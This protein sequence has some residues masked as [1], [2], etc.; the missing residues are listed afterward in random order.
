MRKEE[1]NIYK[2]AELANVSAATVSKVINNRPGVSEDVRRKVLN[3][4]EANNFTPRT[5]VNAQNNIAVIFRSN[6]SI[7][8]LFYSEYMIC[9]MRGLCEYVFDHNYLITVFPSIMVPKTKS[10]FSIFCKKHKIVGCV[11]GNLRLED[12]YIEEISGV[13][14]LVLMNAVFKGDM[15]YSVCSDDY[16]GMYSAVRYLYEMGHRRIAIGAVGAMYY[17]NHQK[18]MGFKQ[19]VKDFGLG[20]DYEN[21]FD[22]DSFDPIDFCEKYKSLKEADRLPTA[23]ACMNDEETFRA[24]N[25]LRIINVDC[26]K[27]ISFV[28]YDDYE[29]S[30]MVF[31][32][33]T[34]VKQELYAMGKV[35]GKLACGCSPA[36]VGMP[37][38]ENQF[39][40]KTRLME[41]DTVARLI[42]E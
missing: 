23:I 6:D 15:V 19:A 3:C 32:A 10:E 17:A 22:F 1:M 36:A 16:N 34:T 13:V 20:N 11:F 25:A 35:A 31:P 14:P 18:L 21:F 40:F 29:Y 12:N 42:T 39:L 4:I 30:S 37:Y 7:G 24:I 26:P 41:R 28:G 27:D 33:L 8:S 9:I 38:N 2:I 5:I